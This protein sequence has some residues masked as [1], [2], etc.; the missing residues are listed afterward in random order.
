MLVNERGEITETTIANLAVRID[1]R[2]WTPPT[3]SG[4]LPGGGERGRLVELGLLHERVL[5]P[6]DLH[7]AAGLA[8]VNSLRGWR[9]AALLVGVTP[10]R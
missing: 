6:A 1:G 7:R 8:L 5:R 9:R 3:S 2:W 4:C 10:R